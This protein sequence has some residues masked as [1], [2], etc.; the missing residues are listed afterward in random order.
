MRLRRGGSVDR[1]YIERPR[2]FLGSL[3]LN[4]VPGR[5]VWQNVSPRDVELAWWT[6]EIADDASP[7][8]NLAEVE[9]V[10]WFSRDELPRFADLLSTNRDFLTALARKEFS[11]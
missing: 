9:S 4:V 5:R 2:G 7:Q 10:H 3:N 8:P 6:A 11:I 1:Q